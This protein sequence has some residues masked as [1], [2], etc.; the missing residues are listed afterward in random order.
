M[1]Q[2]KFIMMN[3]FVFEDNEYKLEDLSENATKLFMRIQFTQ[4]KLAELRDHSALFSKAKNGYIEDLK[5]EIVTGKL[6]VDIGD[7]LAD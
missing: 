5:R 1:H 2:R 6:G 4:Q 3:R 7:L